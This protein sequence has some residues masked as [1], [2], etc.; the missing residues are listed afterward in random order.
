MNSKTADWSRSFHVEHYDSSDRNAMMLAVQAGLR[1]QLR[2]LHVPSGRKARV[3]PTIT[4][5]VLRNTAAATSTKKLASVGY[6]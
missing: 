2:F 1:L 6:E 3:F 4:I 5:L